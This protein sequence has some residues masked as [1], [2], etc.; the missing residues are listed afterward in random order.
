MV[1]NSLVLKDGHYSIDFEDLESKIANNVKMFILV[2]PHNPSG[3]VFTNEELIRIGEICNKHNVLVLSDEVHGGVVF[4]N[5]KHIPY[6]SISEKFAMNSIVITAASKSFN[7]QGLTHAIL[8]IPNKDLWNIYESTLTG[9]DFGFATNVFSLAAVEAAYRHGKPWLD[10]LTAY[11]QNNLQYLIDYFEVNIPKI[12][13]IKPEGS[14]MVWLDCRELKMNEDELETLFIS[15]ARVALTF[16]SGFG[17]DGEGFARI[18]IACSRK[19][20]KEALKRIEG[21]VN[22]II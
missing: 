10:E 3:R 7:L 2:N 9:Y 14:Y 17:K 18:N 20:L 8:I 6:A 12:K 4:Q 15:K 11:L 21:A 16:G 5:H 1:T 19:L 22:S 13:V